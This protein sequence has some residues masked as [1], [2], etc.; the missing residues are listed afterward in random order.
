MRPLERWRRID[1]AWRTA[2]IAFLAAR[3]ALSAWSF[4][5]LLLFPMVVQ[6]LN[7][8]GVPLLAAFELPSSNRYTYS[9]QIQGTL[10]SFRGW[11]AE[12]YH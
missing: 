2:V 3:L 7:V 5:I 1:P 10:L 4:I 11:R 8:S 6:N 12:P 9:R